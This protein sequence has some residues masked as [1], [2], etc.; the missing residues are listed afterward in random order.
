MSEL[1]RG[2]GLFRRLAQTARL[3]VGV[4]DYDAYLHHMQAH[5][6]ELPPL[7]REQ[8]VRRALEARF[9]GAGGRIRRCPC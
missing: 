2:I 3:M 4:G 6:P 8:F 9:G 7:S 1:A 5:H